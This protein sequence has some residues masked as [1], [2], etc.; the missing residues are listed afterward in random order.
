M[1]IKRFFENCR[2][3]QIKKVLEIIRN[4]SFIAVIIIMAFVGIYFILGVDLAL[5]YDQWI[6]HELNKDKADQFLAVS[7]SK[8]LCLMIAILLTFGSA[9]LF[10]VSESN[11]SKLWLLYLLKVSA[12][13]LAVVFM[14]FTGLF[15]S[16]Y[17]V[18]TFFTDKT[19]VE[20]VDK[21]AFIK[22]LSIVISSLGI[23]GIVT[24]IVSNVLL[25]I[26]E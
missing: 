6:M 7:K 3:G 18:E 11:K 17:L 5:D 25:G 9:T 22:A 12:I 13:A 8:S 24:N 2:T 26:E 1:G 20:Y 16:N 4:V 23:A 21:L 10:A 19:W 15:E 14:V